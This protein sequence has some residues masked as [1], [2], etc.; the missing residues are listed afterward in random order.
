MIMI[1]LNTAA[2]ALKWVEQ[3]PWVAVLGSG[4][5]IIFTIFFIVEA[6]IKIIGFGK[7]YFLD[8]WNIFDFLLVLGSL[9]LLATSIII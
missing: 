3:P 2:L 1:Y 6:I 5:N 9:V 8:N 4:L 7:S